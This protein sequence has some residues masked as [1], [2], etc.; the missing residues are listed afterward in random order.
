MQILEFGNKNNQKIILIHGFQ[1][2]YQVWD[3]YIEHYKND[4]HIIVPILPGHNPNQIE[5]FMSF[6]IVAKELE[7]YF[8]S[9][10]DNNVYVVYGMSMGGVLAA[11]LWKRKKLHIQKLIFDG[12]PLVSIN[13]FMKKIMIKFYIGITHKTQKRDKKTL[14][15]AQ[16]S[17]ISKEY[18]P[19]FLEVL[20]NMTEETVRNCINDVARFHVTN[21]INESNTTIYFYHGTAMNEMLAQKSAIFLSKHYK[22]VKIKSFKGRGHCELALLYPDKMINELKDIL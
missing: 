13:G 18:M 2:P 8:I 5:D 4:Y 10:Y 6:E 7:D 16:K 14:E 3:K 19:F 20:D 12:S 15:Q 22:N 17:I 21:I 11:T 9:K 1:S